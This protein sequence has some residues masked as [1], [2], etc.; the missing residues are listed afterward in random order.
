[1]YRD[2]DTLPGWFIAMNMAALLP[3]LL[4]PLVLVTGVMMFD[5]GVNVRTTSMFLAG[6]AYPLYLL[7]IVR[8]ST[9]LYKRLLVVAV[10]LPGMLLLAYGY[11]VLWLLVFQWRT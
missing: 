7:V 6:V 11:A 4:W 9:W 8:V 5:T 1:V 10:A 2:D 3:I